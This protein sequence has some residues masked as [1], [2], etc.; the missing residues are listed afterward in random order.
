[1]HLDGVD[2]TGELVS[3][4]IG[5]RLNEASD[6]SPVSRTPSAARSASLTP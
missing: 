4:A 3:G 6:F 5:R 2:E 1:V